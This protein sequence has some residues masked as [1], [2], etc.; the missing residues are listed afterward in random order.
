MKTQSEPS[1]AGSL[2]F[3]PRTPFLCRLKLVAKPTQLHP[4]KLQVPC[5]VLILMP[6]YLIY[7]SFNTNIQLAWRRPFVC[8]PRPQRA[9]NRSI[10]QVSPE[11][12]ASHVDHSIS[13]DRMF[14]LAMMQQSDG[15]AAA[16]MRTIARRPACGAGCKKF[17]ISFQLNRVPVTT[18]AFDPSPCRFH[19]ISDRQL[20]IT[21]MENS[22][23]SASFILG[24]QPLNNRAL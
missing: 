7:L 4:G 11:R 21:G 24:R 14:L 17:E 2:F 5:K 9:C 18:S 22:Q 3:W 12:L 6:V 10:V 13:F 23:Q 1:C 8:K 19:F 20:T 15:Q 16:T